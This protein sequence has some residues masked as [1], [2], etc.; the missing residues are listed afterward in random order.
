MNRI[1]LLEC[2]CRAY[3]VLLAAYPRTFRRQ[4]GTEMTQLFRDCCRG[5]LQKSGPLG[6]PPFLLHT[7]VDWLGSLVRECVASVCAPAELARAHNPALDGTPGFYGSDR[8]SPR[9]PALI[10]GVALSLIVFFVLSEGFNQRIAQL[11]SRTP[12][13]EIVRSRPGASR[14]RLRSSSLVVIPTVSGQ[15]SPVANGK[16]IAGLLSQF[17][18]FDIVA[19]GEWHGKEEDQAF[20]LALIR[21]PELPKKARNVVVE[22]GNSLYQDVLD[23]Y[24][25]GEDVPETELRK[26]WRDTTQSPVMDTGDLN[27]C[28]PLLTEIRSLNKRLP[29]ALKLRVIAG[30]PPIDW[31]KVTTAQSF[32]QFLNRRD[33][34]PAD[35]ITRE[36]LQKHQKALVIYGAGHIWRGNTFVKTPNLV[37]LLDKSFPGRTYAVFRIGGV[38]PETQ[39]LESLISDPDRPILLSLKGTAVG[40]LDAN[41]FI[42]RDVPV[43]L[44]PEH[45]QLRQVADGVIYSGPSPDKEIS[46]SMTAKADP[47]FAEELA[48]RKGLMPHPRR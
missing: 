46:A 13:L 42:G 1:R 24:I 40:T 45:L 41:E 12:D 18:R 38:Y 8:Y 39:R 33:E 21:S 34:V 17:D 10:I 6:L 44:F 14:G 48:R 35:V 28:P 22:W 37:S 19:L 3:R 15:R 4:Y 25:V 27:T 31:T 43:H 9:S 23:R 26:V 32:V 7:G 47:S 5:I 16:V 11:E 29:E 2:L 20:Q 36:V 30:D